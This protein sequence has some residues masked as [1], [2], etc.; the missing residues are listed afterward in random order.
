MVDVDVDRLMWE[1]EQDCESRNES[2]CSREMVGACL[3]VVALRC[4]LL[5]YQRP[6][7]PFLVFSLANEKWIPPLPLSAVH[8][9]RIMGSTT[10]SRWR[11]L[12]CMPLHHN[13]KTM[14][15]FSDGAVTKFSTVSCPD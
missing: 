1:L 8:G 5:L 10:A 6:P 14:T 9:N 3:S 7:T 15:V 12:A 4:P 11:P 2:E 13:D